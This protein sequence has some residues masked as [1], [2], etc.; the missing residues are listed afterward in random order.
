VQIEYSLGWIYI[1]APEN[2]GARYNPCGPTGIGSGE[3]IPLKESVYIGDRLYHAN[4]QEVKLDV[5]DA[6]GNLVRGETLDLHY[7]MFMVEL[8]DGTRI[9]WGAS[10]E[11]DATY[12]DYRMKT[13]EMLLQILATYQDL[14]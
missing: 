7:E 9:R 6:N 13:R 11:G 5:M 3:V 14:P 1:S 2:N 12:E 4:G 8:E 10:P